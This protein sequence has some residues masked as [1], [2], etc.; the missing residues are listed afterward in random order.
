MVQQSNEQNCSIQVYGSITMVFHGHQITSIPK[1]F[2]YQY[3][4]CTMHS[5]Q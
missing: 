4:M 5:K 1:L 2:V 3:M